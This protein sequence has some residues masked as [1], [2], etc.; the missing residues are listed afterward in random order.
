MQD[1]TA[2]NER[3]EWL[4]Q[5]HWK[6][7]EAKTVAACFK[8]YPSIYRND[9]V[10]SRK[11]IVQIG[12][13]WADIPTKYL[14]NISQSHFRYFNV[15]RWIMVAVL[16]IKVSDLYHEASERVKSIG[17]AIIPPIRAQSRPP[18]NT[19]VRESDVYQA[20]CQQ[21]C[22]RVHHLPLDAAAR[23]IRIHSGCYNT[24]NARF[25][26][27]SSSEGLITALH[28][29]IQTGASYVTIRRHQDSLNH[30]S[31]CL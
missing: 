23:Q 2:S 31:C 15:L 28:S 10:K 1:Y 12:D 5:V 13:A 25:E 3:L 4:R 16:S 29:Y 9:W 7:T 19:Y 27:W 17:D 24:T 18:R 22:L 6:K 14:P 8:V 26:V 11:A 20:F 30:W 21:L